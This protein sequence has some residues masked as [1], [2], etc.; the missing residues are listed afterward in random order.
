MT[1]TKWIEFKQVGDSR[2]YL[3]AIESSK[4]IPF[5]IKRV[6][7]LTSL[8]SEKP[9]GFH[10]HKELVQVAICLSGKSDVL[11]DD[12]NSKEWATLDNSSK[13]LVIEPFIWHEM[14]N[15][16]S[17]CVFIVL[18]SDV[19]DESDYIRDYKE[20]LEVIKP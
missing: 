3:T 7:Y 8:D 6:Y 5:D 9:R 1:L 16:S 10:A 20:F 12:G 15:F 18:A 2:G 14:H 13:G 11:L 19:Y 4:C 17:D